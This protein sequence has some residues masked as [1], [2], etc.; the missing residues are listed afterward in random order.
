MDVSLRDRPRPDLGHD[1]PLQSDVFE[2][3]EPADE[4]ESLELDAESLP[5]VDEDPER[6]DRD[7]LLGARSVL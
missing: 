2:S 1:A 6:S 7:L 5:F 4:P 3:F